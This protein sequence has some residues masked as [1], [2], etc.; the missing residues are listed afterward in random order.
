MMCATQ[1]EF[2]PL[3]NRYFVTFIDD[4]SRYCYSYLLKYKD[5]VPNW[6]KVYKVEIENQFEKKI[7]NLRSDRGEIHHIKMTEYCLEHNIVHEVIAPYILQPNGVVEKK[8]RTLV[9]ME[10]CM[11]LRSGASE[12]L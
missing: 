5:E 12:N 10:N 1:T 11:L 8:N 7:K 6:F 9:D 3:S 2:S 4:H